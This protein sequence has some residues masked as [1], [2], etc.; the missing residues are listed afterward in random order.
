MS[1]Q[2]MDSRQIPHRDAELL[3]YFHLRSYP[4]R[5]AA[6]IALS[7]KVGP[8]RIDLV[9]RGPVNGAN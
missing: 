2:G 8:G 7:V 1:C 4:N 9:G 6:R 3:R 5:R